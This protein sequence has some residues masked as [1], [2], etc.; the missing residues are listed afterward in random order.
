M[1]EVKEHIV[2]QR[3]L[4]LVVDD[5]Q[6]LAND[7]KLLL[8]PSFDVITCSSSAL[9]MRVLNEKRPDCVLLDIN[10]EPHFAIDRR[11]EGLA[12]LRQL[13]ERD[14]PSAV[15]DIPVILISGSAVSE[16]DHGADAFFAKPIDLDPLVRQINELIQI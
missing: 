4:L 5:D 13:R 3:P 2:R 16:T 6:D 1:N 9:G 8:T 14:H 10:M 15:A 12:F 7:L 11:R